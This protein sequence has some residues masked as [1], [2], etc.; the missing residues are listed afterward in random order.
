MTECHYCLNYGQ[1]P[2][3]VFTICL[4]TVYFK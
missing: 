2:H 1:L 3:A 4:A